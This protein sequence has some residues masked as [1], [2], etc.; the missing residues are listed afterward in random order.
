MKRKVVVCL[1]LILATGAFVHSEEGKE[2]SK[3]DPKAL[4]IL[5]KADEAVKDV[6]AVRYSAKST[7]GGIAL[8][9]VSEAEGE[10]VVVGWNDAWRSPEKYFVHLKTTLQG[11]GEPLELT[12]GGDGEMFFLINHTTKKA[13]E[14][15]DPAVRRS[16]VRSATRSSST[17]VLAT[18]P[19]RGSSARRT[20]IRAGGC[21]T[22]PL[23]SR[24]R[25]A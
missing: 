18:R 19:R 21:S 4:E 8:N 15:M 6:T 17:T 5:K 25:E 22:S 12:G 24:A 10:A 1:A 13:Y 2:E 16:T 3:Q 9:F 11:S 23:V 14:D 7:P 20:T